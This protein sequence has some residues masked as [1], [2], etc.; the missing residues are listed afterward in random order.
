MSEYAAYVPPGLIVFWR[1]S[2]VMAQRFDVARLRLEGEALPVEPQLRPET[3]IV[4]STGT[5]AYRAQLAGP[6]R[7]HGEITA[8]NARLA[9]LDRAGRVVEVL[10]PLGGYFNPRLSPDERT[11]AVEQFDNENAG[12]LWTIDLRRKLGTRLTFDARRDSDAVWAPGGDRLAWTRG[13]DVG[14]EVLVQR[15]PGADPAVMARAGRDEAGPFVADW[16]PDGRTVAVMRLSQTVGLGAIEFLPVDGGEPIRWPASD[17][18]EGMP[19]FSPD[20]RWVAYL[21]SETGTPEVYVR[22]FPPSGEKIRV[23]PRGG[24][25]R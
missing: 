7:R 3:A 5:L 16:S 10:T 8:G 12:D 9:W 1:D 25:Q 4:S 20:G 13:G 19:R 24:L 18:S 21:S 11:I 15:A 22:P 23:S 14:G 2:R 17:A 6:V